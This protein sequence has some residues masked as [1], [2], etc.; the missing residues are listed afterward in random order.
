MVNEEL[1][2]G[3]NVQP[4]YCVLYPSFANSKYI[5]GDKWIVVAKERTPAQILAAENL[6]SNAHRGYLSD[7]ASKKLLNACN[8][9]VISAKE[10]TAWSKKNQCTFRFKINFITLTL[11]T[12][13]G[14]ISDNNLKKNCLAPL[15]SYLRVQHG[16][17]SYVWKCEAQ[18]NGNLHIHLITDVF[19]D[20]LQ[21]RNAWNRILD[22]NGL[23]QDYTDKFSKLSLDE[24]RKYMF[25][26]TKMNETQINKAYN[27]G[28]NSE[29]KSPNTTDVHSMKNIKDVGAYLAS[30]MSKKDTDKR[31]IVGKI[32]GCSEALA[33][34]NQ[35]KTLLF[36][37]TESN[38]YDSLMTMGKVWKDVSVIDKVTK[39]SRVV[40]K[41]LF[42]EPEFLMQRTKNAFFDFVNEYRYNVRY[43]ICV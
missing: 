14:E 39:V 2:Y 43:N 17:K 37:N 21:L 33:V 41:V 36:P 27:F 23:V 8:W 34:K 31:P 30:Y 32:W 20:Q 19:I 9:L 15:L 16:L 18:K 25:A 11:P 13:Q 24:Y 6:K 12:S 40:A 35:P 38:I 4:T 1:V 29:W 26:N 42:Y 28:V 10:K 3:L 22:R 5:L 7:K